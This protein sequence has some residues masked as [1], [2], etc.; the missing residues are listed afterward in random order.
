MG[1]DKAF[2]DWHGRPLWEVQLAKLQ[3]AGA[4]ELLVCGRREQAFFGDGFRQMADP[5][6]DLGPL[7]GLANA[8]R[9][10][11]HDSLLVLAVDMPFITV[12]L[13]GDLLQRQ[14]GSQKQGIVPFR[15]DR[16]EPL[17]AVYPKAALGLAEKRLTGTNRSLQGFCREAEAA[18]LVQRWMVPPEWE[19]Q[20]QSVNSPEDLG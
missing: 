2:L 1:S 17:A 19:R 11:T 3:A 16:F 13:L 5:V 12:E 18:G 8:L 7:S 9:A 20:F 4:A 15:A 14:P 10:A 6:E